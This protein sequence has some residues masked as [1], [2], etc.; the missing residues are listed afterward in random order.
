[1]R[2]TLWLP[3][4]FHPT[5]ET[6]GLPGF[7]AIDCFAPGGTPVIVPEAGIVTG[8]HLI[9]WN[10]AARVGGWTLYYQGDSGATYFLTHFAT[11]THVKH[12]KAG[13]LLGQVATVPG[14]WWEPHIHEGKHAGRYD[15][16]GPT[17]VPPRPF[18][19]KHP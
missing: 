16:T 11:V 4:R 8:V 1:M 18:S 14:G 17:Q 2:R 5:H 9:E 15:Y 19:L 3:E 7:P 13:N 12:R 10:E 6:A